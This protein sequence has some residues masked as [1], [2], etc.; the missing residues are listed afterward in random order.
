MNYISKKKR[1]KL[2]ATYI[3][4]CCLE[5]KPYGRA[6]PLA[7]F[8]FPLPAAS[9]SSSQ[10]RHIK[11]TSPSSVHLAASPASLVKKEVGLETEAGGTVEGGEES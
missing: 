6:M 1:K 3:N 8:P 4:E 5:S 2:S 10:K 7:H 11:I 9:S